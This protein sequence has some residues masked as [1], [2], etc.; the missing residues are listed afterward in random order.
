VSE[1][2]RSRFVRYSDED[3]AHVK[4]LMCESD[5]QAIR[6]QCCL[7]QQQLGSLSAV[8]PV[9]STQV[10]ADEASKRLQR[11]RGEF[12]RK[13]EAAH[14]ALQAAYAQ[15]QQAAK[16]QA[17]LDEPVEKARR[18]MAD[19]PLAAAQADDPYKAGI[20]KY[21]TMVRS[22]ADSLGGVDLGELAGSLTAPIA[23]LN[24]DVAACEASLAQPVAAP[25]PAAPAVGAPPQDGAAPPATGAGGEHLAA[26]DEDGGEAKLSLTPEAVAAAA[27]SSC[28][29][30]A[31]KRKWLEGRGRGSK[32]KLAALNMNA[33]SNLDKCLTAQID[34]S[35]AV[36][37]QETRL[38]GVVLANVHL[39]SGA[40]VG[41]LNFAALRDAARR[42]KGHGRSCVAGGGFNCTKAELAQS[43]AP[44]HFD[45]ARVETLEPTCVQP[46]RSID[47]FI[48]SISLRVLSVEVISGSPAWPRRPVVLGLEAS[49][50][51]PYIRVMDLP[52]SPPL[53]RPAG[54]ARRAHDVP[55]ASVGK[56]VQQLLRI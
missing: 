10:A 7:L 53:A 32:W 4:A 55:W 22:V 29:G 2:S 24:G 3:L 8:K 44:R 41:G 25:A 46:M 28:E 51:R 43:G 11:A 19:P 39:E 14:A 12:E 50:G 13:K 30:D 40:G 9:R 56:D 18:A 6:L 33:Y 27:E 21:T 35:D 42:L 15:E 16:L 20:T 54:R 36:L 1:E 31:E 45:G 47:R 37:F 38:S 23:A 17:E 52:K 48:A 5:W 26:G 49:R 34:V